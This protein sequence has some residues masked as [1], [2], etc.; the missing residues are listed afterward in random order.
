MP[1]WIRENSAR[2]SNEK[3]MAYGYGNGSA[4]DNDRREC[5]GGRLEVKWCGIS[6]VMRWKC[7]WVCR[8]ESTGGGSGGSG[9]GIRIKYV[10]PREIQMFMTT[11]MKFHYGD[12]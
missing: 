4:G 11:S 2:E 1:V 10:I 12:E 8:D 9:G 7:W 5:S 3:T 6:E